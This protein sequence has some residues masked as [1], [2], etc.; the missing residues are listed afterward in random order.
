[1]SEWSKVRAWKA[2]VEQSTAGSN[3]VLS[4]NDSFNVPSVFW[5]VFVFKINKERASKVYTLLIVF[6]LNLYPKFK[7]RVAA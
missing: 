1:M 3:P 4:A 7:I 2:R 6:N 5:C